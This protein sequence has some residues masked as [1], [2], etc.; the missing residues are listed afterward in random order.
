[1]GQEEMRCVHRHCY[2]YRER[3]AYI[4]ALLYRESE[5]STQALL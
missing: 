4:E 1:M 2:R 5:V 3:G